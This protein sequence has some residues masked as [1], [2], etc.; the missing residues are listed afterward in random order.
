MITRFQ[1]VA[2]HETL[3]DV[4]MHIV[5]GFQ[6]DF[7]VVEQGK[8][9]GMLTRNQLLKGLAEHGAEMQVADIMHKTFETAEATEPL[10]KV[11]ERLQSCACHSLPVMEKGQLVGVIDMENVGE[12]IAMRSAI[13][14]S[15]F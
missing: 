11:F 13:R 12:F 5:R 1:T 10:G 7:P 6:Q 4:T 14:T 15:R 9:V 2:P 8:V 3:H